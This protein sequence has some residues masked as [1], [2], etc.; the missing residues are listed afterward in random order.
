MSPAPSRRQLA[1]R[2]PLTKLVLHPAITLVSLL[3]L[4]ALVFFGTLYQTE[5]GLWEAQNKYF[6][7]GVV[8]VGGVF[9]L[10][11]AS[12]VLWVLSIQLLVTM[13][14][15]LP[16]K[17]RKAGLW[18]VHLS[19][20]ALLLGG[21]ITQTLAVES[22]M[23]LAEGEE[24]HYTTSYQDWELALWES[25]G[26]SNHVFAYDARYLKADARLDLEPYKARIQVKAYYRNSD[27]FTT[28]ATRGP[29]YVNPS[30]IGTLE[31][32]KP[33]KEVTRNA[34]GLIF[35]LMEPGK[36]DKEILLYGLE[37]VPLLLT[38]SGKPVS[39]QLRL[40]HYPLGFSLKLT[41]FIKNVHPGTDVASS[42][43]SY[44]DLKENGGSRPVKIWMNNPLRHEGYTFFQA[45]F[46]QGPGFE[47]STFA[48]VT[49]PGRV[50]PYVSSLLVFGGMLLH[51]LLR[52]IP[53]IRKEASP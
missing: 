30:G 39:L 17:A 43:E 44:A 45:S 9:P 22:Q 29:K 10:P 48:V 33:D 12:L 16:W 32:R 53:F 34:P 31:Q 49:N 40:K 25:R 2:H 19:I 1:A 23:T 3:I 47:K 42:F 27:A 41:D 8:L 13:A 5:H 37:Q 35:T 24:G 36:P 38:L 51:F 15:V 6:G 50:L 26:D 46:S 28:A 18:I 52:L 20:F 11:G 14:L 7:Y 21:F 4:F